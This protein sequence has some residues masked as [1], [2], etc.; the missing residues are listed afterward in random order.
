MR[1][2]LRKTLFGLSAGVL[3][4]TTT[5]VVAPD[6][7][8]AQSFFDHLFGGLRRA[9]ERPASPRAHYSDPFNSYARAVDPPPARQREAA[10]PSRGFC[11]RTCDGRFF[12]VQGAG[13]V[14][15]A[16]MCR[17]FCPA[18][19]TK[20]YSGS[21]ID[22]ATARDGSRYTDLGN[23]FLFRKQTVNGCTCN[24]RDAYGLAHI[25]ATED[26]T[27]KQGDIVVN[28][29]GLVAYTGGKSKSADFTPVQ[30]YSGFSKSYREM[31][32]SLKLMQPNPGAPADVV[33]SI[34]SANE[35]RSAQLGR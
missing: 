31:L 6:T 19:E 17:A 28:R 23:A 24:G 7:A 1:A 32:A 29:T 12:P 33:S 4:A 30:S 11:V 27:L 35:G 26:P 5:A 25:K 21:N 3:A 9:V 13:N 8:S 15:A 22:Y 34:P 20:I 2:R 18:A 10:G 16:E 14:S